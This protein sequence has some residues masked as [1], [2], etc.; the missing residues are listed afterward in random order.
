VVVP[1]SFAH[2]PA[3]G[4]R[5]RRP[6]PLPPSGPALADRYWAGNVM[7]ETA[8]HWDAA[9]GGF[10][11][12]YSTDAASVAADPAG[13]G[14]FYE[15]I[16]LFRQRELDYF[17][18]HVPAFI[19]A[20]A[21]FILLGQSEGGMLA[22]RYHNAEL[23]ARL[24][25]RVIAAWSCEHNYFVAATAGARIC[26]GRCRRSTP[27]LN[28]VGSEDEYFSSRNFSVASRVAAASS[29]SSSSPASSR[30]GLD[31]LRG[32]SHR[33]AA[34]EGH[35]LAAIRR[36]GFSSA[37]AAVVLR[38]ASH[39]AS[40]THDNAVRDLLSEF[41]ADPSSFT[42]GS[43]RSLQLLC[44]RRAPQLFQCDEDGAGE[45]STETEAGLVHAVYHFPPRL[46]SLSEDPR[47][48]VS[49]IPA[50]SSEC[51]LSSLLSWWS[52]SLLPF[53]ALLFV[54]TLLT[55][56]RRFLWPHLRQAPLHLRRCWRQ[57]DRWAWLLP[58]SRTS[59]MV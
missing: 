8:C 26:E 13:W 34:L 59:D 12:C 40:L 36:G 33:G 18:T 9:S 54:L 11:L 2:S 48:E 23:E 3:L 37:S 42:S 21:R 14:E 49:S 27:V 30:F 47:A 6:R 10:P 44:R 19:P 43:S 45:A 5:H 20:D 16:F 38:G 4:L 50:A 24:D 55:Q 28:I 56:T 29:S 39:D 57:R 41:L 51:S 7:Y 53:F 46:P 31:A 52:A 15:R 1:D 35:C 58:T 32:H 22:A 25:A 17:V